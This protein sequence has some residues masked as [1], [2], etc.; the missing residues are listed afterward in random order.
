ME[1]QLGLATSDIPDVIR[2][3]ELA[4]PGIFPTQDSPYIHSCGGNGTEVDEH[5]FRE[6]IER[7]TDIPHMLEHVLL[8]LLSKGTGCCSAYCGQRSTDLERGINSHYYLVVDFSSK[9]EALVAV[10]LGF[11]LV[12]S[13]IEGRPASL[14]SLLALEGIR[15]AAAAVYGSVE[16]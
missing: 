6:E 10:D 4:L 2:K 15:K 5:S 1:N 14:N 7:G 13:W 9:L 16:R 8:Y 11:E 3:M 12:R